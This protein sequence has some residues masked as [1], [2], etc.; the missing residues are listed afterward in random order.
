MTTPVNGAT[1]AAP[2]ADF[3]SGV[4]LEVIQYN[5]KYIVVV[6]WTTKFVRLSKKI[7]I[8]VVDST[9]PS[10]ETRREDRRANIGRL[11][12]SAIGNERQLCH[13]V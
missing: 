9:L 10:Y 5:E 11:T 2:L 3:K 7:Q 6:R 1:G 8:A 13:K 12:L 4:T